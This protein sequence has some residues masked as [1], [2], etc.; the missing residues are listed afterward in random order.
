[1]PI[2]Q[3]LHTSDPHMAALPSAVAPGPKASVWQWLVGQ[4]WFQNWINLNWLRRAALKYRQVGL[5]SHDASVLEAFARWVYVNRNS[6]DLLLCTGDQSNTGFLSDLQRAERFFSSAAVNQFRNVQ[7]EPTLNFIGATRLGALP[8]NHDRYRRTP[9]IY[10]P[11]G[12]AFDQVFPSWWRGGR[13]GVAGWC[14][15]NPA[16]NLVIVGA[17]FALRR[18]DR[19]KPHYWVPGWFGQGRASDRIVQRLE[20]A[21]TEC[22]QR[23][24]IGAS[25]PEPLVLWAIHF[26]PF[27][28]DATLQLLGTERLAR[29]ADRLQIPLILSGHTHESKIKPLTPLTLVLACGTTAQA[30]APQGHDFQV[31]R[32][33]VPPTSG[34]PLQVDVDYYRYDCKRRFRP[35]LPRLVLRW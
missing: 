26:D 25:G 9:G 24:R 16:R 32:L 1:M 10:L 8:G 7:G 34:G 29:A 28:P 17:D 6:F 27:A 31:L 11:G 15:R 13:N 33:N 3:L 5:V 30:H 23:F 20:S 2:F 22:R 21:T 19:G 18:R 12:T 4:H 35:V 14:L